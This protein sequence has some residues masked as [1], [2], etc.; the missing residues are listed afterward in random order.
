MSVTSSRRGTVL[1]LARWSAH[2]PWRAIA[3][4][5]AFVALCVVL[6][7]AVG[8]RQLSNVDS[9]VGESQRADRAVEAARFPTAVTEQVLVQ[10]RSGPLGPGTASAVVAELRQ[11][12]AGV[13]AV[14]HVGAPVRAANGTALLLPVT[15]NGG[16]HTGSAAVGYA[17]DHVAQMQTVTRAVQVEHPTLVVEQVGDASLQTSLNG[18]VNQDLHHA[19][20]LSLPLTLL[21][22]V[23]T[24]GALFAAGVPVILALTAVVAAIGL[25]GLASHVTPTT[26]VLSSVILLIGMAVGVDYSLF[27]VRRAR[28]E[29]ARGATTVNSIELAA[30]T[31]GRAVLVS[32][33]SVM[34][35][36]SGMFLSGNAVFVSFAMGTILVVAVAMLGSLTVLPAIL[37]KLGDR[38]DRPRV[39]FLHRLRQHR[40]DPRFWPAVMRVVLARP[41]ASLAIGVVALTALALPALSMHLRTAGPQD[42]PRSVAALRTYDRVVAAFPQQ[43][44]AH[45]VVVW[46]ASPLDRVGVD[47]AIRRLETAATSTGLFVPT[48][49]HAEYSPDGRTARVDL[50]VPFGSDDPRAGQS[51]DQLRGRLVPAAFRGVDGVNVAVTGG[52]AGDA[53]FSSLLGSRLPLVI[54]FVLAMSFLVLVLAFR[55]VVV[56]ATAI[57]LNLLSVAAA[58]GLLVLVFQHTW[59]EGL[60]GFHSNG[61]VISWLPLFLF[62]VLFGLSMDYHV[63]V[64][65]RIR[66]AVDR[67]LPTRQAVAHGVTASAGVV[68]SAAVVMVGVF[69][70][71]ATLSLLDFKQLG[72]GLAGAVLIDAFVVRA[73]LLPSAM[74]L[75]GR[76]NWWLPG[77]LKRFRALDADP[78]GERRERSE[79]LV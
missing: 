53:D 61:A 5:I 38:V 18:L 79:A 29:R 15:M 25:A 77:P 54:G 16:G 60:L 50:P 59:A 58:Y 71:F 49:T 7:S 76:H 45:T 8:T 34:I 39:P 56:A 24:F 36:M 73:L 75:L 6:G 47:G 66:E 70:I 43:G 51:L 26:D 32:G 17:A 74:A 48:Q 68:T 67:G 78:V 30:A 21:I 44:I 40:H 9:G 19:E 12:Y 23:V 37:A 31:S 4:W 57:V 42:L 41:A 27:Y 72:I 11:R 10:S 62:V 2:H 35:A 1:A 52:V 69:G 20:L 3:G 13:R 33:V 64:V 14:D 46:A 63:F 65:S 22:L 28:E 55:S